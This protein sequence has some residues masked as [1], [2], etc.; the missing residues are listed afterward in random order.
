MTNVLLLLQPLRS[1]RKTMRSFLLIVVLSSIPLMG[2]KAW[3]TFRSSQQ[4]QKAIDDA[5]SSVSSIGTLLV[6][7]P[8]N[9]LVP[10]AV[11]FGAVLLKGKEDA[12]NA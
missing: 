2:C 4:G 7:P 12:K 8:F 5:A 9:M 11:G 1:E 6:P 10:L 3:D